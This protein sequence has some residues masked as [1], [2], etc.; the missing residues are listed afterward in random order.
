MATWHQQ[1]AIAH[2]P[3]PLWHETQWTVVQDPP[4]GSLC[5]SRFDT[6]PEAQAYLNNLSRCC[7]GKGAYVLPPMQHQ[8]RK[9]R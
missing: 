4:G 1:R 8:M 3:V 2:N 5:L 6:Q 7:N 9:G